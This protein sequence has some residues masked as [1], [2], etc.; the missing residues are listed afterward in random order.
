MLVVM[1]RWPAFG[2]CKRRLSASLGSTAA[3]TVQ[4]ALR[5]HTL[6]VASALQAEGSVEVQL[7]M[8]GGGTAPTRMQRNLRLLPQGDGNLGLRMRRQ[9]LLA[10]RR[11]GARPSLIIGTDLPGLCPRDVHGAIEALSS[12]SLVLGPAE[13]GGYWL[14]GLAPAL[15]E[16]CPEWLF[17]GLPWGSDQ[18]LAMTS[19]RAQSHG[20]TPVLLQRR[21]DID[22]LEDL[23]PWLG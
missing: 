7:A 6:A 9:L 14:M 10:R 11:F 22:R 3:A 17:S 16:S 18:V 23:Q 12:H 4:K 2:R 8:S 5:G 20:I 19:E 21:N 15:A 13:D 1:S